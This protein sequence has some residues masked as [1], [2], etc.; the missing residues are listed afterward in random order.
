MWCIQ[1]I[2][3][4]TKMWQYFVFMNSNRT[5]SHPHELNIWY[6]FILLFLL[7]SLWGHIN[8][9]LIWIFDQYQFECLLLPFHRVIDFWVFTRSRFSEGN[10]GALL[11]FPKYGRMQICFNLD[12]VDAHVLILCRFSLHFNFLYKMGSR[13]KFTYKTTIK[14]KVRFFFYIHVLY[15]SLKI[16]KVPK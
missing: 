3:N 11:Q 6:D 9:E 12:N 16:W 1:S 15:I 10:N 7:T 14:S 8:F 5:G 4:L 13:Y 2:R